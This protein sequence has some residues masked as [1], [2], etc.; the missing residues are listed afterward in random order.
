MQFKT[1]ADK[2][3]YDLLG[4]SRNYTVEDLKLRERAIRF[5]EAKLE[6]TRVEVMLQTSKQLELSRAYQE[7]VKDYESHKTFWQQLFGGQPPLPLD[8]EL[9]FA[10]AQIED[11]KRDKENYFELIRTARDC[12]LIPPVAQCDRFTGPALASG[13]LIVFAI[14]M[15]VLYQAFIKYR[16]R[17]GE[18]EP[19]LKSQNQ[20][21]PSY[22][23][24]SVDSMDTWHT[25]ASH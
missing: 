18:K 17:K 23:S 25:L 15:Y 22:R 19:L 1:L 4:A 8:P 3:Y 14:L 21:P 20:S 13:G 7:R 2:E 11:L 10:T 24:L 9:Q 5:Y 12:S 6:E 16:S